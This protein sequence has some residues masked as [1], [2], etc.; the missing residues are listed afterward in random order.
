[1]GTI[2]NNKSCILKYPKFKRK[3]LILLR[4]RGYTKVDV[5][6]QIKVISKLVEIMLDK[7]LR[8]CYNS[9]I[10]SF[11]FITNRVVQLLKKLNKVQS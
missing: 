4:I 1:M 5:T 3:L 8:I 7:S 6:T 11:S 2:N 10:V 9:T